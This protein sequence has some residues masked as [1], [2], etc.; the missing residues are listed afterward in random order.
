MSSFPDTYDYR[1]NFDKEP[2]MKPY[3]P[4]RFLMGILFLSWICCGTGFGAIDNSMPPVP[5]KLV[6][7]HH[8][9]G[10]N[11]L[12]DANLDQPYG[13]LGTAL[14]NNNYYVSATNYGWGPGGI[15]DD[16]DIP[17][18]PDWFTGT[19]SPGV[20]SALYAETG[21][22]LDTY[23]NWSRMAADPGGEN[24]IVMFK[25][26]YPNSDLFGNPTDGPVS[27]PD[28]SYTVGNAKAVYNKIL[29]YF[30][31]RTDKLFVVITAPPQN[32]NDYGE[33][34]QTASQRA[35]N[36]RAF[37]NWLVNDWLA[38]YPH[39][40]VA[41]F[42]YFNVLTGANN[43]HW[44]HSHA[45]QHVT[46]GSNNFSAYP[47]GEWDSHP[48]TAG[49]QKATAEFTGL[50]NYFYNRW[51]TGQ[52]T[53]GNRLY[54]PHISCKNSWET[55]VCIINKDVTTPLTGN[56]RAYNN[57]GQ[58]VTS[59]A[60]ALSS[61]ARMEYA[62]GSDFINPEDIGYMILESDSDSACG[63]MKFYIE[64]YYRGAIPATS[65]INSNDIHIPHIAS[66]SSWWTGIS[67][68]NTTEAPKSLT[69]EFNNGITRT[70]TIAA[71]AHH[72]F[73]IKSMFSQIPQPDIKSGTI[74]NASGIVGL[75]LFGS[76]AGGNDRYLSGVLL[77]EDTAADLYYPHVAD[78][79]SWWTGIVAYN[80]SPASA[81]MTITPFA[82]N[83]TA[84]TPQT[85][86][87]AGKSK[88]IGTARLLD[89]PAGTA[90]FRI[91]STLPLTGFELFGTNNRR[92]L[93]GYT[94]VNIGRTSGIFP[95]IETNGWTGIALVNSE[96]SSTTVTLTARD[97][98]GKS[99][100]TQIL[101]LGAYEKKSAL[102]EALFSKDISQATYISF[103]SGNT[104]V[105]FQ[106]NA[107][108]DGMLLD[109]LP[110]I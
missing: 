109:A 100:A 92:Q 64:S 77:K 81:A 86:I 85:I 48:N 22:N 76:N 18:W 110:G 80:P 102:A 10:G 52:P 75:E 26:C 35:A 32:E 41:V 60:I 89:L 108:A 14:K 33:D 99:I 106:L 83:G 47:N 90:W 38:G 37:N 87:L 6:F 23:G 103:S 68:L 72:V 78:Y 63:Y 71:G 2:L 82:E 104:I 65:D 62:V 12:A 93:G 69:F 59:K 91:L 74:K 34:I 88:Y 16:T 58:Q 29:T 56:L 30:R 15:G 19:G 79:N 39:N 55:E 66:N 94:G 46:S 17:Y 67:L 28:R 95:K 84:L 54:F 98:D 57:T 7:I 11:W 97:D 49:Q 20:L 45:E 50:L 61:G 27:N 31:T 105:G 13:G 53:T 5:V 9:T 43:H 24:T 8:S 36:A 107:S 3:R 96:N 40:N 42:D 70:R 51:K 1:N 73:S 25:S 4:G 21:K 101:P 44:W